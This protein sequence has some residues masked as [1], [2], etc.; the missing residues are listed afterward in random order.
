MYQLNYKCLL[1]NTVYTLT[2][3]NQNSNEVNLKLVHMLM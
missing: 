1:T 2:L 3:K